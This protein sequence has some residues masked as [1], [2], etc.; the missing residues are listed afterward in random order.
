[1][2]KD[3]NEIIDFEA[4]LY[5]ETD[6]MIETLQKMGIIKTM[7]DDEMTEFRHK[8]VKVLKEKWT[9]YD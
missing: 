2:E 4:P 8:I 3:Q 5:Y 9:F 6:E 1:M 7:K